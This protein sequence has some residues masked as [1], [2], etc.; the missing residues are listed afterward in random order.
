MAFKN[1][2]PVSRSTV[3]DPRT[4]KPCI[5]AFKQIELCADN[6]WTLWNS[7]TTE[8]EGGYFCCLPGEIGL[9]TGKCIPPESYISSN[10]SAVLV[11]VH[12]PPSPTCS[13]WDTR[14]RII[15]IDYSD[16]LPKESSLKLP[17]PCLHLPAPA[18][19][20][21]VLRFLPILKPR[22]VAIR[23]PWLQ[24]APLAAFP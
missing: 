24:R 3:P 1:S 18:P 4:D 10:P 8:Y 22:L 14:Y 7:T 6:S 17:R 5:S 11:S 23:P 15:R 9:Q 13:Q 12:A 20:P 21:A 2:H 16:R 19:S